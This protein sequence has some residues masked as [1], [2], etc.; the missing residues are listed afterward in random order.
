MT[1]IN[2]DFTNYEAK[3]KYPRLLS[4]HILPT[5]HPKKI[6]QSNNNKKTDI[7]TFKKVLYVLQYTHELTIRSTVSQNQKI[8]AQNRVCQPYRVYCAG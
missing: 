5:I 6:L 3:H 1:L 8:E 7:Y 4:L 2:P